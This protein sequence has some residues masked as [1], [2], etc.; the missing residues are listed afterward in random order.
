MDQVQLAPTL[1]EF[2]RRHRLAAGLSQEALAERATMSVEAISALERGARQAPR[3]ETVALLADALKLS[4][5]DRVAFAGAVPRRHG[6]RNTLGP[7][8][9]ALSTGPRP[10]A[11]ASPAP[12]PDAFP[13][14]DLSVP[15]T[16]LVGRERELAAVADLLRRDDVRLLTLVG[17]PG[18]GKTRLALAVIEAARDAFPDGVAFV[19]LADVRDPGLVAA[20]LA[21]ALGADQGEGGDRPLAAVIARLRDKR[22]LLVLDNFEHVAA[23]ATLVVELCAACPGLV[24]LVTSRRPL[25]VRGEQT[26]PVPPLVL[27]HPSEPPDAEGLGRYAAVRLFV[28]RVQDSRPDFALTPANAAAVA[29]ICQHLDGLPLAIELAAARTK[30]L[31]LSALLTQLERRQDVLANGPRDLPAR[32]R[33]LRAT[34]DW[35]HDLLDPAT[36]TIF[37]R[38]AV[39]A[40][41]V[42]ADTAAM[43]AIDDGE[44][45]APLS[46]GDVAAAIEA[47]A[48]GSLLSPVEPDEAADGGEAAPRLRMLAPVRAYALNRLRASDEE[49]RVRRAHADHYM[50]FVEE[51]A[52]ALVGPDQAAWIARVE[53]EYDGLRAALQWVWEAQEVERGLRLAGALWYFWYVRGYLT[54]GRA[55]LER[56]LTAAAAG[57]IVVPAGA[58]ALACDGAAILAYGQHDAAR[59]ATLFARAL[60]LYQEEGDRGGRAAVLGRLALVALDEGDY[61][62]AEALAGESLALR[63]ELGDRWGAA[64]ALSTLGIV[65]RLHGA[66]EQAEALLRESLA[67]KRELGDIWGVADALNN[68]GLAAREQGRAEE[69]QAL[70]EEAQGL[71]RAVR[72]APG[73]ADALNNLALVARDRGD[74]DRA[75]ELAG[76]SLDVRRDVGDR[77][78]VA[79]TLRTLADVARD[80]GDAERAAALD[81]EGLDLLRGSGDHAGRAACLEGRAATAW[82]QGQA[83]RATQL[84]GQAASVRAEHDRPL[85]PVER[86]HRHE[87]LAALRAALGDDRFRVAWEDGQATPHDN[88]RGLSPEG[89]GQSTDLRRLV[90]T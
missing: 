6:P 86:P 44:S 70:H 15:L 59:A 37:R 64:N 49:A 71:F 63:R 20:T 8:R 67:L 54:E 77:R 57:G 12:R 85:P 87:V 1:G 30:M 25:Y 34:L 76:E 79:A 11:H 51:A 66:Y 50:A 36:Q 61:A 90:E 84:Y 14:T 73:V 10:H 3:P 24:A 47:L 81:T 45:A 38:L 2:L 48:D 75:E 83:E 62:R 28:R 43:C 41:D 69:A 58:H 52:G 80:G 39:C 53:R 72:G 29:A 82:A 23:A 42:S 19:S 78:G 26:F 68:L 13:T 9:P 65:A 22:L 5:E 74:D 46:P 60:S 17:P 18:V 32:Q 31:P 55:W 27:P 21:R 33:A 16:P 35:S 7:A 88:G 56:A 4:Q 40:G 89:K